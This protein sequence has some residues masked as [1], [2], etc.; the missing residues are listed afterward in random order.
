MAFE[1]QNANAKCLR[2]QLNKMAL[3]PLWTT[4]GHKGR[5]FNA[6]VLP[7][8]IWFPSSVIVHLWV[9]VAVAVPFFYIFVLMS[10]YSLQ[11]T[12]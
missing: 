11:Q 12:L 5:M 7:W 3:A 9:F 4:N 1:G 10:L 2:K 6:T 8:N